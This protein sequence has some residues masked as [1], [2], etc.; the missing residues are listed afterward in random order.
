[1]LSLAY[2]D[3]TFATSLLVSWGVNRR[4]IESTRTRSGLIFSFSRNC[5]MT[6]L[7]YSRLTASSSPPAAELEL[8]LVLRA[9]VGVSTASEGVG[10][11]VRSG[12]S[13]PVPFG[14]LG[15]GDIALLE[16]FTGQYA[17][18]GLRCRS[19]RAAEDWT[20]RNSSLRVWTSRQEKKGGKS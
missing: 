12:E 7:R 3:P 17:A 10:E 11:V 1:M 19:R 14:T 8:M 4:I 9:V 18:P 2:F 5:R 15:E 6:F 20:F 16:V 13:A